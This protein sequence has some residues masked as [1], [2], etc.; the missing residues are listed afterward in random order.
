MYINMCGVPV[1]EKEFIGVFDMDTSTVSKNTVGTLNRAQ[2][3]NR[4]ENRSPDIPR[5]F[6]VLSD[7][8][9]DRIILSG[10]STRNIRVRSR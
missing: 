4:L 8:G 1:N 9:S 6:I 2:K 3:E 5:S 10:V 7:G